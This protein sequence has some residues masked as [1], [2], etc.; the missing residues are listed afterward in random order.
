MGDYIAKRRFTVNRKT[1]KNDWGFIKPQFCGDDRLNDMAY[2]LKDTVIEYARFNIH[3][4][5]TNEYPDFPMGWGELQNQGVM[6][7][8]LHHALTSNRR[9]EGTVFSEHPFKLNKYK[10]K[11]EPESHRIDFWVL[12]RSREEKET[13][14]L[15]EYK[16]KWGSVRKAYIYQDWTG[17]KDKFLLSLGSLAKDWENDVGKLQVAIRY[18]YVQ[19][20][21]SSCEPGKC[22]IV[23]IM[24][25]TVPICQDSLMKKDLVTV[26]EKDFAS[27]IEEISERLQPK[28]NW[29]AYWWLPDDRQK[30]LSTWD[31]DDGHTHYF[32][33]R[34]MYF[35]ARLDLV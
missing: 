16:H 25:M 23:S 18:P 14:L 29:K 8:S 12:L 32:Y 15:I 30:E 31:D 33:Y 20:S 21:F 7:H 13:V 1:L 5:E 11:E 4:S 9:N 27:H 6:F 34:G 10:Y 24:L 17:K 2:L 28:P 3:F 19:Q 22:N 26:S 35:L